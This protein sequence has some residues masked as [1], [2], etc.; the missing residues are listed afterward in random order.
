MATLN[1][2]ANKWGTDKGDG[3]YDK[4][5]YANAYEELI[6]LVPAKDQPFRFLEIGIWDPRN[7]G[8]SIRMW[9][10]FLPNAEIVGVDINEGSRV[11]VD[12]CKIKVFILDQGD[13]AAIEKMMSEVGEVDF[14]VDDGS[15]VLHHQIMSFIALWPHLAKGGFYCIEDLHAPQSQPKEQ[16]VKAAAEIGVFNGMWLSDKLLVFRKE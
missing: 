16:I 11:L 5:N 2:L 6:G 10:E 8:A 15:H 3:N 1:E 13:Q 12:E 14:I 9:R 4:H 7:P